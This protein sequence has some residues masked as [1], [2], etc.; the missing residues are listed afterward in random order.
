M[1]IPKSIKFK[2]NLTEA[3]IKAYFSLKPLDEDYEVHQKRFNKILNEYLQCK[4]F[5][6]ANAKACYKSQLKTLIKEGKKILL[7]LVLLTCGD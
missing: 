7:N 2:S 3:E 1:M 5:K 6:N 4:E